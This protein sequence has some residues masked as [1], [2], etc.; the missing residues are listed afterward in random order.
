M[1]TG[2]LGTK[3][4]TRRGWLTHDEV[5]PGDET[6]GYDPETGR[7]EWTCITR[8][9]HYD[10]AEVW[11]IGGSRWHADATPEHRWWSDTR[12]NN[13]RGYVSERAG[14]VRTAEFS[15]YDRLRLAAPADTNGIP[16]LSTEDVAILAW[17]QGD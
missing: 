9:V 15:R 4:L 16:G 5:Q 17:L 11:R 10:D 13:G 14:F 3:I 2:M 12:Q 8:V 6:I 7:S 1:A